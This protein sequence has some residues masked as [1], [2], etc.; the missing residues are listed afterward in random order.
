MRFKIAA[1]SF[2]FT[3]YG[4][5]QA[6]SGGWQGIC[7]PFDGTD[8]LG[9]TAL[10]FPMETEQNPAPPEQWREQAQ[11]FAA[12]VASS[13]EAILS[14]DL[15]GVITSWNPAAERMYG[16]TAAEAI[17]RSIL[18]LIPPEIQQEDSEILS[19]IRRGENID[20][21]ETV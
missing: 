15:E 4:K 5:K 18:M 19:R 11:H 3:I 14:K 10:S 17:D 16:Y 8:L 13:N 1:A 21:Y 2:L 6:G 20:H 12:L 7:F 9:V